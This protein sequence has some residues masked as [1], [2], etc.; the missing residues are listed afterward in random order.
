MPS[1][2]LA[3][4]FESIF[5]SRERRLDRGNYYPQRMECNG[6]AYEHEGGN[7]AASHRALNEAKALGMSFFQLP[8]KN[9][10][11]SFQARALDVQAPPAGATPVPAAR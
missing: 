4:L 1:D 9:F 10:I 8:R 6:E 2:R 5:G 7:F 11:L 3:Q